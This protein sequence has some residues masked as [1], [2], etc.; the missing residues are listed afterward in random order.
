MATAAVATHRWTREEYERLAEEGYFQPGE[1]VE[2]IDGVIYEMTPQNSLH[3]AGIRAGERALQP[4]F[5]EGFDVR[6]QLPLA[7]G[8]DSEPEPD[9]AV[10]PGT[11]EDYVD[12][13][14]T[15]AVLVFEAADS[16]LY[17][18]RKRKGSLYARA[19]IQEYWLLN[20]VKSCLQVYRNPKD[21]TY[22]TRFVL[23]AGD[24][25]S[26]LARPDASIPVAKL[27]P[28]RK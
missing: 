25:V 3:A 13:H 2:L 17:H 18:D 19:G 14:P 23:R 21:G 15:S 12:G 10:V 16:S 11:W 9:I 24:T 20:L 4:V 8:F 5:A 1:R 28:P 22:T 26:P 7:L 6:S 27:I